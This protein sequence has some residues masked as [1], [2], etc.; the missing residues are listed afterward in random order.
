MPTLTLITAEGRREVEL[1]ELITIGRHSGCTIPLNDGLLSKH[2][3]KIYPY[4]GHWYVEDLGS[5]NGTVVNGVRTQAAELRDGDELQLGGVKAVF[6]VGRP[7]REMPEG[8]KILSAALPS[9][10]RAKLA[11]EQHSADFLPADQVANPEQLMRDYEKLRIANILNKAIGLEPEI[12]KLLPRLLDETFKLIP[13]DRGCILLADD[14]GQLVPRAVKHSHG[15]GN[16]E[17]VLS[18][19]ILNE[20]VQ[21]RSAVLTSDAMFDDR[22]SGARSIIATKMRST[23][24]VPMVHKGKLLGVLH[25]DSMSAINAFSEKDLQLLSGVAAQ[26]AQAIDNAQ[27]AKQLERSALARREFERL[28]PLEIV[29]QVVTGAVRL[30]RGGREQLTTI[31]FSDIRGFTDWSERHEPSYIVEVLNEYFELMVEAIHRHHGTL[32]K[33]MGDGIMALFGAPL[34]YKNDVFNAVTCAMDMMRMLEVFNARLAKRTRDRIGMGIGINTGPAIVGYMGSTKSMEYT[35]IGDSVNLA[36]RLCGVAKAGEVIIST[37]T[38]REVA[39][40]ISAHAM[41]PVRVKGKAQPV[42]VYRL[43][44]GNRDPD[45]ADTGVHMMPVIDEN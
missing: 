6:S 18:N 19:T 25:A 31:L 38:Y 14:G 17:I 22:F 41:A 23:M 16:D 42:E 45:A 30:E 34:S 5:T 8:V 2:H 24:C 27:K 20:V 3:V 29:E 7:Q 28:L 44:L 37:S 10:M 13:A 1:T 4:E 32:D 12:E 26:A 43:D 39:H 40:Q 15:A 35:A 36:S 33:F 11:S 9:L 21:N